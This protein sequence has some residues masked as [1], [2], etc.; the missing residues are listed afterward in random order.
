MVMT[1]LENHSIDQLKRNEI[2]SLK[3]D[4]TRLF[5][6]K[7]FRNICLFHEHFKSSNFVE[8]Y[9]LKSNCVHIL[10]RPN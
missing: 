2:E 3:K 10:R 4:L 7:Y 6:I 5:K 8:G 9:L 1:F